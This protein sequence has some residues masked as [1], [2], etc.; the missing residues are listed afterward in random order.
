MD[1]MNHGAVKCQLKYCVGI[2]ASA[3]GVEALQEL[4]RNMPLDTGASFIVVQHL[5]PDS[6]SMMDKILQKSVKMPE[7]LAEENMELRPN[8]VYLN[9]PG[10]IL[11][12]ESGHLHLSPVHDRVQRYAPINQMLN[13]LAS[14]KNIHTIAVILSGSGSDGTIGI[15]S[16]KE[17]GGTIIVQ[18]PLEAQYAS[19]PQSAIA[20]GLV[21][22][23][24]NEIGRASCRERVS[25][26]V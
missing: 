11:E 5:S 2:G 12:V 9:I 24:E 22:L 25:S 8:E 3:G 19:M 4:F 15:G 23:T 21:D 13:S 16:V 14:D 7:R 17:N 26:P 10:M 20:T 18:K 1:K 6:V